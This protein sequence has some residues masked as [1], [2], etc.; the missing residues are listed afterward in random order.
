MLSLGQARTQD[1]AQR[2]LPVLSLRG[3]VLFPGQTSY[4]RVAVPS[5][6]RQ[7][8]GGARGQPAPHPHPLKAKKSWCFGTSRAGPWPTCGAPQVLEDGC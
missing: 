1:E 8:S 2:P 6:L 7:P 5:P 4:L 3:M